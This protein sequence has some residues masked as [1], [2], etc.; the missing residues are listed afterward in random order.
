MG[1]VAASAWRVGGLARVGRDEVDGRARL[2]LFADVAPGSIESAAL[3]LAA[4]DALGDRFPPAERDPATIADAALD[5]WR[6]EPG[7][8][9]V[10]TED[11]APSDGRWLW[12]LALLLL[13]AEVLLR[14]PRSHTDNYAEGAT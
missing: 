10:P 14:R 8:D 7:S 4:A 2:L 13:G 6:R 9:V 3:A 12:L 1:D 11:T 5:A